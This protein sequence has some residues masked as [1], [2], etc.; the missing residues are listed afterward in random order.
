MRREN[1]PPASRGGHRLERQIAIVF[2]LALLV[3]LA[4]AVWTYRT[5]R[6]VR[7]SG[8]AIA[9]SQEVVR[10][11]DSSW[12]LLGEFEA[13]QRGF[14]LTGDPRL[15]AAYEKAAAKVHPAFG[16]IR[17]LTQDNPTQQAML[18]GLEALL[19]QKIAFIEQL[20][21]QRRDRGV[22][23]AA[24]LMATGIGEKIK[25]QIRAVLDAMRDEERRLLL[26]RTGAADVRARRKLLVLGVGI[27]LQFLLLFAVYHFVS[28]DLAERRRTGA[29]LAER[30][31]LAAFG[32]D[33]G[34]ALTRSE[35]LTA[36]LKACAEAMV[37]HLGAAI[38]SIW[39]LDPKEPVLE[40]RAEAG[41][42]DLPGSVGRLP[43]GELRIG[44]IAAEGKARILDLTAQ[45]FE[46]GDRGWAREQGMVSFAGHPLL[47]GGRSLGV[48]VMY[49]RE[50]ISEPA[51]R[52]MATVADSIAL[53]IARERA[54]E[55]LRASEALTRSVIEGMLEGLVIVNSQGLIRTVNAAAERIFGYAREELLDRPL[56][57]LIPSIRG[58]AP[59]ELLLGA[60]VQTMGR[61]PERE[62]RR[63]DGEAFP[64]EL[65]LFEF[66]TSEGRHFGGSIK[67]LSER[68]EVDR[69]KR[70]FVSTVSHELRT[71][72][73]S[74]RGALGL[75]AG[76]AAGEVSV[77]AKG[78]LD[79]ALKNSDRLALLVNDILDMEKIESGKLEFKM[80]EFEVGPVLEA[81][82]E[83]NRSYADSYGVRLALED[84]A[85]GAGIRGD[86]DR[87]TQ[88]I[89]NLLSN[90]VK[91][92]PRGETVALVASRRD[93][94]LRLEVR[95]RGPGIPE[96]FRS[97]IFGRFQQADSSDT[98]QKGG[99]GLGLAITRLIVETLGGRTSFETE[100]GRGSTFWIE[101][102]E[103]GGS[104]PED[105]EPRKRGPRFR[106]LHVD[107]D[108]D[109]PR[110]V[111]AALSEM[112]DVEVAHTVRE[113]RERLDVA[114]Y[115]LV[116]LD[117]GLPDGSG[118]E[119]LGSLDRPSGGSTP[120]VLFTA[121]EIPQKSAPAA[122]AILVKSRSTV[123]QLVHAVKTL[124]AGLPQRRP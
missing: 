60:G 86:A 34:R 38:A 77:H 59:Q 45:P 109:L 120:F 103:V 61:V 69:L 123:D 110:I 112:A 90:A 118:L 96:E 6:L 24:A 50:P 84:G 54:A 91:F 55:S 104:G 67:D 11:I 100:M 17:K 105:L 71:P 37:A 29:A 113:A 13:A 70:E 35:S 15:Y 108:P 62:G 14:I 51:L 98:R 9:H 83:G 121:R 23:Y 1:A 33:V 106:I 124:I 66:W 22:D 49:A 5:E 2:A 87:L 41:G 52:A 10:A 85:R 47:V 88:A 19:D 57:R 31:R 122:A 53:G 74:I 26:E 93:G 72:L 56:A 44:R 8:R 12:S 42:I 20:F 115:D 28:R 73:T 18:P 99:T 43:V 79:I 92:S 107:D 68:R 94:L 76:G 102:P 82:I 48:M 116:V 111:S 58:V 117:V 63:K 89:T 97:R 30:A 39:V 114:A 75:V 16:E 101:L 119:L 65:S 32:A 36:A 95:D 25:A 7:D 64:V 80:E 78:L 4:V 46:P 81:A 21:A 40:R 3:I 27:L